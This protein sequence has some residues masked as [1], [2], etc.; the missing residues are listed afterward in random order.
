MI[1]NTQHTKSSLSSQSDWLFR[2]QFIHSASFPSGLNTYDTLHTL[3]HIQ[4]R[5]LLQLAHALRIRLHDLLI[6]KQ[7]PVLHARLLVPHPNMRDIVARMH[8]RALMRDERPQPI[9]RRQPRRAADARRARR[10]PPCLGLRGRARC[11]F[12][13]IIRMREEPLYSP[14]RVPSLKSVTQ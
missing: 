5:Q 13:A 1:T 11:L 7:H 9:L 2:S 14:L 8:R 10:R 4:I 3:V 6:I 12:A